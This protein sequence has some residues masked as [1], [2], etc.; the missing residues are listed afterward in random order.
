[1]PQTRMP[2]GSP[3]SI[4]MTTNITVTSQWESWRLKSPAA[5]FLLNHLFRRRSKEASKL[6]V[7][8]L[9]DGNSPVTGELPA[10]RA[11]NAEK[12]SFHDVM[13]ISWWLMCISGITSH[14]GTFVHQNLHI[15]N[16]NL[17]ILNQTVHDHDFDRHC[18]CAI[19][20]FQWC[21]FPGSNYYIQLD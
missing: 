8:C 15:M 17:H 12:F 19:N 18:V 20:I 6:R 13:M 16:L 21:F 3:A 4:H 11:S 2:Q 1:M 9:C 5:R 14:I 7:T 10:Q